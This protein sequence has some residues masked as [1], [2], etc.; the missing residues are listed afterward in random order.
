VI[1]YHSAVLGHGM[2]IGELEVRMRR[3]EQHLNRPTIGV[4]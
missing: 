1:E 3:A 2:L 4:G